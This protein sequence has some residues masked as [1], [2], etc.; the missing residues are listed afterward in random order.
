MYMSQPSQIIKLDVFNLAIHYL[1]ETHYNIWT[2]K[3]WSKG[4]KLKH[5]KK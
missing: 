3:V 5:N 4:M 2:Q 1:Q